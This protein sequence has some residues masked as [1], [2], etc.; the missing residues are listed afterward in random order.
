MKK[1]GGG[2]VMNLHVKGGGEVVWE[3]G[4]VLWSVSNK[5]CTVCT[6][7]TQ[8]F[9]LCTD[10]HCALQKEESKTNHHKQRR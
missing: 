2:H 4:F 7:T 6:H 5:V 8:L 10:S 1:V 9:K 3:K